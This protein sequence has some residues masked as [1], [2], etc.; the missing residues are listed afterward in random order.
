MTG[1]SRN[2]KL[3]LGGATLTFLVTLAT[4][5]S[6]V[7]T[8][9]A[10]NCYNDGFY[11]IGDNCIEE[12]SQPGYPWGTCANCSAY[13]CGLLAWPGPPYDPDWECYETC[14]DGAANRGCGE[15]C[16]GG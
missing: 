5:V 10:D 11:G 9:R 16:P 15:Y 13:F 1:E 6:S 2:W 8:V 7:A 4:F 12:C 14:R 3:L